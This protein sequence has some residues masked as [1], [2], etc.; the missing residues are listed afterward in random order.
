MN[1]IQRYLFSSVLRAAITIVGGLSLLALLAQGLSQTDLI[2]DNRQ[3]ALTYLKV[4][5]L[6]APQI[7]AI[8]G[9]LALFVAALNS[10]NRAHRDN[11]IVVSH[12]AG[13]TRWQVLSPVL[14]LATLVAIIHLCVNLFVQPLAQREL[15]E[16]LSDARADLAASL[17][18]PGAFSYPTDGL[19]IYAREVSGGELRGLLISDTRKANEPVDYI[20]ETGYMV[21][22]EGEAA[23]RLINGQIQQIDP[24]GQLSILNFDDYIF[25]LTGFLSE[26]SDLVLKPSDRFLYELF[27]PDLGDFYQHRDQD[28][29]LAEAHSRLSSPLLNFTMVIIAVI[30]VIGGDFSRRGYSRRI[31]LASTGAIILI[32]ITLTVQPAAADDPA[33]N[34]VQYLVPIFASAVLLAVFL[35]GS[36]ISGLFSKSDKSSGGSKLEATS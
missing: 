21:E 4:V 11:E 30:A 13:M 27:Y 6:G 18:R 29:Y 12:A 24:Q 22:V 26:D 34:I 16:T 8:L 31:V 9:P 28:K 15:R 19:T 32:M 10:L 33:L 7:V 23:L 20:A 5:A 14:R 1:R 2:V 25:E 36:K 3:S 35:S 17:I